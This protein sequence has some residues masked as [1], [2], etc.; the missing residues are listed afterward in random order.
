MIQWS[1]FDTFFESFWLKRRKN[2]VKNE[3]KG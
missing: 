3:S 1:Y 2:R